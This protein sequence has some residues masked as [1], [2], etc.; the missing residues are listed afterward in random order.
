MQ[1]DCSIE[2]SDSTPDVFSSKSVTARK[3]HICVECHS[4]INIGQ[5]YEYVKGLWEG[6]WDVFKTCS[7]CLSIRRDFCPSGYEF[8]NLRD[9][10][11]NCLEFDYVTGETSE[12][13]E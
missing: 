6:K 10:I 7:T 9:H 1:C 11:W 12:D 3:K 13:E 5:K 2:D 4:E 8:G